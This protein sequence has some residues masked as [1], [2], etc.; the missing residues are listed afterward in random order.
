[1]GQIIKFPAQASKFGYKRVKKCAKPEDP[2]QLLLFPAPRAKLLDFTSG[3]S[4]FEQAL[5]L[6]E[7]DDAR[8]AELYLKAIGEQ[9][10]VADCYCNLGIL[11]S[12]AGKTAKAF[13]SFTAALKENPRHFEAHYNL[14]NMY[15]DV[16]D[17]RLAQIHYEI[18]AE[19]DRSSANV[20]FNLAL[21]QAINH[22]LD[23]AVSALATYQSLA[24]AEEARNANELMES[25][26]RS[27]AATRN[28]KSGS[29][30]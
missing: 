12:K 6:D 28:P 19:V 29:I 9:D 3:M 15:F 8:A 4:S 26:K 21:V 30:I 18:A 24:P 16:N 2:D 7:R 17:Y 10:C 14:G 23:A 27:L 13:D 5:L 22:E 25:L 11:Q 1:M 20:F